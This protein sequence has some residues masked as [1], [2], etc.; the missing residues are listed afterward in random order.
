[1]SLYKT[2]PHV[3][4]SQ[5]AFLTRSVVAGSGGRGCEGERG[6]KV[7]ADTV[8]KKPKLSEAECGTG[9]SLPWPPRGH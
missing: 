4:W 1:M 7:E 8:K 3:G 9:K 2:Q 5:P 6:E